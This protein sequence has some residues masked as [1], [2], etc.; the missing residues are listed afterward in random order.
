MSG[1]NYRNNWGWYP[2]QGYRNS[3]KAERERKWEGRTGGKHEGGDGGSGGEWGAHT[4]LAGRKRLINT[5]L[6]HICYIY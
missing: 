5:N 4:R 1:E 2:L 6:L 3:R